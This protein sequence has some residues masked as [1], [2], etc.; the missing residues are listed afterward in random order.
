MPKKARQGTRNITGARIR[1]LRLGAK[2]E[3]TL[4]DMAGRLAALGISIERSTLGK[5]ETGKRY[6]R[7]YELKAFARALRVQVSDILR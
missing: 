2:P 1:E 4:E 6:V 7:D 3:I 5:L